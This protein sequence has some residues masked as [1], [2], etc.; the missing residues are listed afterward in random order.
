MTN[1][2]VK[3]QIYRIVLLCVETVKYGLKIEQNDDD[4][5][6]DDDDDDDGDDDEE[7]DLNT[8]RRGRC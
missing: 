2:C 8:D 5:D 3:I 1:E 4:D 6:V 7:D